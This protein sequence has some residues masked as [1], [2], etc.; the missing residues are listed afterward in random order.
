MKNSQ[1][2]TPHPPTHKKHIHTYTHAIYKQF[3]TKL[4][5]TRAHKHISLFFR[6]MHVRGAFIQNSALRISR[7]YV[8]HNQ[9]QL[10]LY[11]LLIT[12]R[13]HQSDESNA[14]LS[15]SSYFIFIS[16]RTRF[17]KRPQHRPPT[18]MARTMQMKTPRK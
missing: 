12:V 5:L 2:G 17:E 14:C 4:S 9:V 7:Q 15:A 18:K 3:T 8:D 6:H 10:Q 13:V 1:D 11:R 16:R